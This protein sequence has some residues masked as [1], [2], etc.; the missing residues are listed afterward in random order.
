MESNEIFGVAEAAL[1]RVRS[2]V[3]ALES[4]V[5]LRQQL[6]RRR[7]RALAGKERALERTRKAWEA[8]DQEVE[9]AEEETA[10]KLTEITG[11]RD[12]SPQE[13]GRRR[14]TGGERDGR[15]PGRLDTEQSWKEAEHSAAHDQATGETAFSQLGDG[16][17]EGER[18][19][20]PPGTRID[21]DNE[22]PVEFASQTEA[23]ALGGDR[24]VE[25]GVGE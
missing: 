6:L 11:R 18:A 4:E 8:A 19:G 3:E 1:G 17:T 5:S 9:Q 21:Q 23:T 15:S 7:K 16:P 14:R 13:R 2:D 22:P 25:G 24:A 20:E 12:G 10:A